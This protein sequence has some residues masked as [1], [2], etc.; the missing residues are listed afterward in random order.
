MLWVGCR[1]GKGS[2]WGVDDD[3]EDDDVAVETEWDEVLELGGGE[4]SLAKTGRGKT[5]D[6]NAEDGEEE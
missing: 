6:G 2:S 4:A 1:S 3:D 5:D